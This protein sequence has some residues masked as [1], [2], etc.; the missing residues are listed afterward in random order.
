MM[1][2]HSRRHF[3]DEAGIVKVRTKLDK[4]RVT[5]PVFVV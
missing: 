2:C 3:I 5:C 1:T 4:G